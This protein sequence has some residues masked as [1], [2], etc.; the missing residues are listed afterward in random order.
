MSQ[1]IAVT[2][3]AESGNMV[4][5]LL[6]AA[7]GP[8]APLTFLIGVTLYVVIGD[9]WESRYTKDA[10]G[11]T[12]DCIESLT[13]WRRIS[14]IGCIQHTMIALGEPVIILYGLIPVTLAAWSLL[15]SGTKFEYIAAAKPAYGWIPC[16]WNSS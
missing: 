12:K 3:G 9:V 16:L 4:R 11:E 8:T 6:V 7:F 5:W 15:F 1:G 13:L 2:I 10:T 14:L